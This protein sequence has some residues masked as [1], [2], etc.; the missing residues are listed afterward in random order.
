MV[1]CVPLLVLALAQAPASP[2]ALLAETRAQ[3]DAPQTPERMQ[4]IETLLAELRRLEDFMPEKRILDTRFGLHTEMLERYRASGELARLR[5]HADWLVRFEHY[6]HAFH[7]TESLD[8]NEQR[9]AQAPLELLRAMRK[10]HGAAF[11]RERVRWRPGMSRVWLRELRDVHDGLRH[12]F[13][14]PLLP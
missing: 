10:R 2:T 6:A 11:L 8:D 13:I 7:R 14:P 12:M 9:A 1:M 4:R 3:L 5:P